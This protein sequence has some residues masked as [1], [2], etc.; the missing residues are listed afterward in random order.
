MATVMAFAAAGLLAPAG[1]G[2]ATFYV[3]P[4]GSDSR[5][6]DL[7]GA[8]CR[9]IGH[10]VNR[11]TQMPGSHL[12]NVAARHSGSRAV[13]REPVS[14][15]QTSAHT[16]RVVID[17]SWR[18]GGAAGSAGRALIAPRGA[19]PIQAVLVSLPN[20]Q[21][22]NIDVNSTQAQAAAAVVLGGPGTKHLLRDVAVRAGKGD[23]GV[24]VESRDSTLQWVDV[25]TDGGV[26]LDYNAPGNPVLATDSTFTQIGSG[27]VVRGS[28]ISSII[29][30]RSVALGNTNSR[31]VIGTEGGRL[32]L[33][34]ALVSGGDEAAIHLG[35]ATG[36]SLRA[37][38]S[39]I[40]AGVSGRSDSDRAA[41]SLATGGNAE[42]EMIGSIVLEPPLITVAGT[43]K[44]TCSHT[45]IPSTEVDLDS[46]PQTVTCGSGKS[47]NTH[48]PPSEQFVGTAPFS[49][50]SDYQLR[51]GAPAIN[52]GPHPAPEDA[53]PFD[54]SGEARIQP[55]G[56]CADS[57]NVI[58]RGAL[59]HRCTPVAGS[60][61]PPNVRE[62][63]DR[64][65]REARRAR[66]GGRA[67]RGGGGRGAAGR[68]GRR[69]G[70]GLRMRARVVR[71][72]VPQRAQVRVLLLLNRP[73]RVVLAVR[74]TKLRR[75]VKRARRGRNVIAFPTHRLR[76]VRR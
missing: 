23:V 22:R 10:A 51:E 15:S 59:E 64:K 27:M 13:Y 56:T 14:L 25:T 44:I 74:G 48:T 67:G 9:T 75:V 45:D 54:L 55:P 68:G 50:V 3:S 34:S 40:D 52:T 12:I 7:A 38:S 4:G 42:V 41:V 30:R 62:E 20:S 71:A 5:P 19:T 58:D 29:L 49:G 70:A 36:P 1:A 69:A 11:A 31:R 46:P 72:R 6:C 21:L 32:F 61:A 53:T 66:G 63:F 24:V 76:P 37:V 39:T 16:P 43:A 47:S 8:P 57:E 35:G 2:A 33:D 18:A 26:A 17:G 65:A 73:A 28:G 60:P